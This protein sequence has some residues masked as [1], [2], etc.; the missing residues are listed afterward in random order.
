MNLGVIC[1]IKNNIP[2]CVIVHDYKIGDI[3]YST[4]NDKLAKLLN[5]ILDNEIYSENILN[6]NIYYNDCDKNNPFY[7]NNLNN[8]LPYPYKILW[9]KKINGDINEILEEAYD[10]LKLEDSNEEI[11]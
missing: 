6:N 5:I 10:I 9:I 3:G 11:K 1:N 8:Y 7:I 2:E 4:Y